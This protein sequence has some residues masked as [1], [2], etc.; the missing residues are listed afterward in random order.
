M[1]TRN[2]FVNLFERY[3]DRDYKNLNTVFSYDDYTRE[4]VVYHF[5]GLSLSFWLGLGDGDCFIKFLF[6]SCKDSYFFKLPEGDYTC[7]KRLSKYF[8]NDGYSIRAKHRDSE[9]EFIMD[10][11]NY[12]DSIYSIGKE[13]NLK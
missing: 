9:K 7:F 4:S 8:S 3:L 13:Y 1:I 5:T 6:C 10:F 12:L 11:L 2:E